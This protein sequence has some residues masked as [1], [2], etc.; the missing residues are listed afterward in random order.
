[1]GTYAQPPGREDRA[2]R[3]SGVV[4][5]VAV[6]LAVVALLTFGLVG[7]IGLNGAWLYVAAGASLLA[8]ALLIMEPEQLRIAQP[9]HRLGSDTYTASTPVNPQPGEDRGDEIV[10]QPEQTHSRSDLDERAGN[11]RSRINP[12]SAPS[13]G[14]E[15]ALDGPATDRREH[16]ARA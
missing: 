15:A 11:R 16:L 9:R 6:G 10:A 13:D 8:L 5:W 12:E 2:P 7:T 3:A 4:G 1:M 14:R